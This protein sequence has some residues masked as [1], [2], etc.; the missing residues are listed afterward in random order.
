MKKKFP[1]DTLK[2]AILIPCHNEETTLG[3][4]IN[5]FKEALPTADIFVC[6]NNSTDKSEEI[7]IEANVNVLNEPRKGN[8]IF[9]SS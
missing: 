3:K 8:V 6:N 1:K 4:V 9:R 2:L 5:S 7:A